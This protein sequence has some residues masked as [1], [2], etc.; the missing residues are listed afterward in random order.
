MASD[1][2]AALWRLACVIIIVRWGGV[3]KLD[4]NYK[5]KNS[6]IYS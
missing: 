3:R 6:K 2:P 4:D 5:L 1:S